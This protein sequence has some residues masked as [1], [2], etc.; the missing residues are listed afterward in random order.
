MFGSVSQFSVS[1]VTARPPCGHWCALLSIC[2]NYFLLFIAPLSHCGHYTALSV[3]P[4]SQLIDLTTQEI[5][6]KYKGK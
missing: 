1:L 4:Y 2:G 6:Y 5:C 3:C